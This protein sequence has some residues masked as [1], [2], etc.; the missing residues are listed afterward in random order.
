MVDL[1]TKFNKE[2]VPEMKKKFGY[3][4]SLAVPKLLKVVLN[5]GVGRTRDDKQFIENMTGY[6]SLIAGQKL[7]PR[8]ARKAISS[9]KTREGMIIGY[10]AT[11]RRK[12][13][14]DF[15][16]R[17]INVS[18]PRIRDFRGFEP[19]S[20]DASGNFTVGIKEHIVF[21]E[22]IGEDIKN[23]FGFEVTFATSAETKE[24]ALEFFRL[25]GF[26]FKK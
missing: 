4:N 26:P 9:F 7:Y 10:S 18:V 3:K 5:V 6:M 17:F 23:I 15:T 1:K 14:Y 19:K 13:M 24:E 22:M 25:M 21:P 16:E 2:V 12:K 20:I 8:P 11:L